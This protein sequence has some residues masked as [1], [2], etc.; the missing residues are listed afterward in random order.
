[1]YY[2]IIIALCMAERIATRL[3]FIRLS[4]PKRSLFEQLSKVQIQAMLIIIRLFAV[5]HIGLIIN[6]F[7]AVYNQIVPCILA[8][9]I[10][11]FVVNMIVGLVRDVQRQ[12]R[13]S[14]LH[15]DPDKTC[16]YCEGPVDDELDFCKNV[17]QDCDDLSISH[18]EF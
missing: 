11:W 14:K 3:I 16:P 12:N 15:S 2:V 9:A 6:Y 18:G 8:T 7:L 10:L 4:N 5:I 13:K 17:V 1:M